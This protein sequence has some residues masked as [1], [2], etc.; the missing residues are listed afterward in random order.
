[1][2]TIVSCLR[3]AL[4][5]VPF[6]YTVKSED[7]EIAYSIVQ[8]SLKI[9]EVLAEAGST[10]ESAQKELNKTLL[11]ED[12]IDE[13]ILIS[14]AL[15][16]KRLYEE[17][18]ENN[19]ILLSKFSK[20]KLWHKMAG[21]D[22]QIFIQVRKYSFRSVFYIIYFS[23]Y[24][25]LCKYG[26]AVTKTSRSNNKKNVQLLKVLGPNEEISESTKKLYKLLKDELFNTKNITFDPLKLFLC[27]L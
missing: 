13:G 10:G 4:D 3:E 22:E 18:D 12:E 5:E 24:Q 26:V 8:V 11:T 1:M 6:T 7:L 16:I 19:E 2:A 17:L 15:K 27:R 21:V 14:G 23:T 9:H 20:Y 25:A